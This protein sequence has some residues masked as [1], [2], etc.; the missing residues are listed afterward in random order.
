MV[1][2]SLKSE[3][4]L[5]SSPH[6]NFPVVQWVTMDNLHWTFG[7]DGWYKVE[8]TI[9]WSMSLGDNKNTKCPIDAHCHRHRRKDLR[10][11]KDCIE[12]TMNSR[13]FWKIFGLSD[14]L[15]SSAFLIVMAASC[16]SVPLILAW[17]LS[18][19][20]DLASDCKHWAPSSW[21]DHVS[22]LPPF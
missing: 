5:I 12:F 20:P 1:M 13:C 15:A 22:S 21:W 17:L 3:K 16:F 6:C 7:N 10:F 2:T 14:F 19:S 4:F 11:T 8:M 18:L 9:C